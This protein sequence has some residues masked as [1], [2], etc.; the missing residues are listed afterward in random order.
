MEFIKDHQTDAIQLRIGKQHSGQHPFGYYLHPGGVTY[1]CISS[2]PV[3]NCH[4]GLF[5]QL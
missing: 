3:A 1:P 4:A 5:L 2:G